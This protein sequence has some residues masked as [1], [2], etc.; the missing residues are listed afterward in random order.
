M[1]CS[2]NKI[3]RIESRLASIE[4]LL[5]RSSRRVSSPSSQPT[6]ASSY[7]VNTHNSHAT[8]TSDPEDDS[9]NQTPATGDIGLRV[10][11]VAAKNAFEHTINQDRTAQQDP[12]LS[13]ALASLRRIVERI[14]YDG[15]SSST[16][17]TS[18]PLADSALDPS[19]LDW[20]QIRM[21]LEKAGRP[22]SMPTTFKILAKIM[23]REPTQQFRPNLACT[24]RSLPSEV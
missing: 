21:L 12:H 24:I 17:L 2:E 20:S 9:T 19:H 3:D 7:S 14:Q 15:S 4:Q 11:S 10:E 23:N 8:H 18:N 16:N 1:L 6:P 13:S 22:L 5:Q